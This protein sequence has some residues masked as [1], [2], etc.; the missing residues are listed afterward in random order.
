MKDMLLML[1]F[2]FVAATIGFFLVATAYIVACDRLRR[3]S[4]DER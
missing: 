2:I 1:D 3:G 4:T